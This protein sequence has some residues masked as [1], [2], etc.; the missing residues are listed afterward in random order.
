MLLVKHPFWA[1]LLLSLGEAIMLA[2]VGSTIGWGWT[3]I[4]TVVT[5]I[6]GSAM[7]KQQGMATWVRIQERLRQGKPPAT[8]MLEGMMLMV[9][10]AFLITPGFLTD[11]IGFALLIPA[12][13]KAIAH[14]LAAK[15]IGRMAGSFTVGGANGAQYHYSS[16]GQGARS[17]YGAQGQ[18]QGHSS[19][20]G[21][22]QHSADGYSKDSADGSSHHSAD[23]SSRHSADGSLEGEYIPRDSR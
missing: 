23:G 20:G 10:G 1:F 11:A 13:R 3:I 2:K 5:A 21:S 18:S 22:T 4:L 7:W 17:T 12:S 14:T 8:E 16:R 9:G 19:T 6:I 15:G